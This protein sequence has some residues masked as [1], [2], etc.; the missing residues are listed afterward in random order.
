MTRPLASTIISPATEDVMVAFGS[1]NET[2]G[3]FVTSVYLLGYF[4]GPLFLAPIS[5]IYGRSIVYN[6]CNFVFLVFKDRKSVV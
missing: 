1:T 5:E 6:I 4:C 3:A 2:V